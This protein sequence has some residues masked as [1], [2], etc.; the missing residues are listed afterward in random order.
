MNLDLSERG[1]KFYKKSAFLNLIHVHFPYVKIPEASRLGKCDE[2]LYFKDMLSKRLLPNLAEEIRNQRKIHLD[3]AN[4]ERTSYTF[5]R[6]EAISKPFLAMSIIMDASSSPTFPHL[7]QMPKG[8]LK[9]KRLPLHISGFIN[10]G[11]RLRQLWVYTAAFPKNP[12]MIISLLILHLRDIYKSHG[13]IPSRLYIQADNCAGENKN[14]WVL[15]FICWL[16]H[17]GFVSEVT[18][19]QTPPVAFF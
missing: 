10:H 13:S 7:Y 3:L 14:R 1:M 9:L 18:L 5:R 16:V 15:T 2:C 19:T 11:L 17:H 8:W 6:E 12:N 4:G